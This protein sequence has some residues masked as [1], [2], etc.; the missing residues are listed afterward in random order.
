MSSEIKQLMETIER[1]NEM[2][3]YTHD[4]L[5]LGQLSHISMTSL[6]KSYSL[7]GSVAGNA[8]QVYEKNTGSGFIAGFERSG[9]FN[10]FLDIGTRSIAYPVVPPGLNSN[11]HQVSSVLMAEGS[12]QRGYT[13]D[14]YNLIAKNY[15]LVSDWEQYGLAK[16]LWKSLARN[17]EV[18]I[19]VFSDNRYRLYDGQNISEKEIWG[20]VE[21]ASTLLVATTKNM[22]NE[23]E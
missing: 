18:N 13:K 7:L 1:L 11:Y 5:S 19:Y 21:R 22:E 16:P 8:I 14:V 12:D 9:N 2:P 6:S 4:D 15:D 3:K 10:H 17:S 23:N 20:G